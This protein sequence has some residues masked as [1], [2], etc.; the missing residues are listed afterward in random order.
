MAT[1]MIGQDAIAFSAV[2]ELATDLYRATE[3][4][5]HTVRVMTLDLSQTLD[6]VADV[7]EYLTR[8][9][10]NDAYADALLKKMEPANV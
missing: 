1:Y 4:R 10:S 6:W 9:A 2:E 5:E 7:R 8:C 3:N